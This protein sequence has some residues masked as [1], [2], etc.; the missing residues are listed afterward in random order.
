LYL[1]KFLDISKNRSFHIRYQDCIPKF[2]TGT[3]NLCYVHYKFSTLA[4]NFGTQPIYARNN[5]FGTA[6]VLVN[7]V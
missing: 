6:F 2:T 3:E 1:A 4:V 7:T 5:A